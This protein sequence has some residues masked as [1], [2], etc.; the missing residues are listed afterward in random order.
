MSGAAP[1]YTATHA[2]RSSRACD[3]LDTLAAASTR[4][5]IP[6][7]SEGDYWYQAHGPLNPR[8]RPASSLRDTLI[9]D[10]E[11]GDDA[12]FR[13]AY[14]PG[15][16][17]N[18]QGG[19]FSIT[20]AVITRVDPNEPARPDSL[21]AIRAEAPTPTSEYHALGLRLAPWNQD[22]PYDASMYTAI[23]FYARTDASSW[24]A[25]VYLADIYSEPDYGY[26][27]ESEG[28]DECYNNFTYP[29]SLTDV[30]QLFEIRWEDMARTTAPEAASVIPATLDPSVLQHLQWALPK[31]GDVIHVDDVEFL[32]E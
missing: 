5:R 12:L 16:S 22:A 25:N 29:L 26:C 7:S 31:A 18:R 2:P 8:C 24:D 32:V 1:R 27:T 13:D 30:W 20:G 3:T 10:L 19:W 6:E 14:P 4:R 11:D 28:I 21:L 15:E 17:R 23:R 9:D